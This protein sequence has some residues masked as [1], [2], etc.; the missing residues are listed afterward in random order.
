MGFGYGTSSLCALTTLLAT[1]TSL[2]LTRKVA[3]FFV[4]YIWVNR[5]LYWSDLPAKGTPVRCFS[6]VQFP[7]RKASNCS[8]DLRCLALAVSSKSWD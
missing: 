8:V 5:F 7:A 3:F 2:S 4:N 1:W 6:V